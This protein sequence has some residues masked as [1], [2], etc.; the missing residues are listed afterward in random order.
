MKQRLTRA[1]ATLVTLFAAAGCAGGPG[2]A[3]A[4][5]PTSA[6]IPS[7]PFELVD[8]P[9]PRGPL[10]IDV[11][12]VLGRE[13]PIRVVLYEDGARIAVYELPQGYGQEDAP[14]GAYT[15]HVYVYAAGMPLLAA[16]QPV[17]VRAGDVAF[18][19][20]N[21]LEGSDE[22]RPLRAFDKD[23]DGAID[24]AELEAGTDPEDASSVPGLAP[25]PWRSRVLEAQGGWYRGEL[26][27]YS[28]YGAGT[29]SVAGLVRRAERS[30]LDFL[31]ITDRN[32]LA[33][34]YDPAFRSDSVVLLPAMEWGTND[35]GVALIYGPRTYPPPP[36]TRPEAQLVCE[37]VQAQGGVFAIAHP[38]FPDAPWQWNIDYANAVEAWCREWRRPPPVALPQ[39]EEDLKRR[40][41]G[42][43]V[44]TI[45][46]A[47]ATAGLSANGQAAVFWDKELRRGQRAAV[48]AGSRSAAPG[49]PLAR[50]VTYVYAAEKSVRGILDGLRMGRTYVSAG[51]DGPKLRF[52][53]DVLH[54]QTVDVNIGGVIP[55]GVQ[56]VFEAG[57]EHAEGHKLQVL[58]DGKPILTKIIEGD[59]FI[60]LFEQQPQAPC[61][62]R[63]RVI[64][65]PESEGFG[66]IEVLAMTSPI[67]AANIAQQILTRVPG[68][69]PAATW[70][71]VQGGGNPE[72][73][74]DPLPFVPQGNTIQPGWQH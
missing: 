27:A 11:T 67:Y 6:D 41:E 73:A 20:L 29:E 28:H 15:A 43:L 50:P 16:V 65:A 62:Y 46:Q 36:G 32:T 34:A 60:H 26:H 72:T 37:R 1:F 64:K 59:N 38:C 12:D 74:E 70:I 51:V 66:P 71:D 25:L 53:V 4:S 18:L 9:G 56:A 63:L 57:V 13:L 17:Q 42:K 44:Y 52:V 5:A 35:R 8:K 48:I 69:D 33:A 24:R 14:V 2:T 19:A 58:K 7:S 55:L 39:L 31:A 30:G 54:D 21:I 3:P 61:A 68:L 22:N 40:A 47:A 10:Q 23:F 45:A 49:V